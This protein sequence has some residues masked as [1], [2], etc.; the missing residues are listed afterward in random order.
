ML[1]YKQA[2]TWLLEAGDLAMRFFRNVKPFLKDNKTYVTQADLE[3]QDFLKQKFMQFYPK[4]G[5]VAEENDLIK[6]PE[7]GDTYFVLDPIDGTAAF[8]YG[9]PIWGIA[10]GVIT[11]QKAVAGY[12]YMP[13][14]DDFYYTGNSGAVYRNET[15]AQ[16]KPFNHSHRESLL[17]SSSRVHR[18]F[19]IDPSY[20]GKVRNL[21]STIAHICYA[22]T[23]SADVALVS[24]VNIWDIAAGAAMLFRNGGTASYIDGQPFTFSEALLA[25]DKLT[26]PVLF[27]QIA[28]I[29]YF[30]PKIRQM[31]A[32]I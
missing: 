5:I 7:T 16:L 26:R 27:G 17:L 3:V 32:K 15:V 12:F 11:A 25:R 22:A 29:E 24:E 28:S 4:V 2:K 13:A 23:G 18:K 14:T 31:N 30:R 9:L 21:G 19:V 8:V 20:P 6:A 1:P 10:L